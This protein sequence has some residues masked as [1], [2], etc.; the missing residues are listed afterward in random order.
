MSRLGFREAVRRYAILAVLAAQV[1]V[2]SLATPAFLSVQNGVNVLDQVAPVGILAC[3]ATIAIISGVF[4]LSMSSVMAVSGITAVLLSNHLGTPLGWLGGVVVGVVLGAVNGVVCYRGRL[5]SFIATLSTSMIFRG[6]AII[7]TGGVIVRSTAD[8]FG[9]LGRSIGPLTGGA[10]LFLL[11]AAISA[12]VLARTG[13][14]RM[15][16]AVGGNAEAARLAGIQIGVVRV[17]VFMISAGLSAL[18]GLVYASRTQ[19]AAPSMALGIELTAIAAAVLGGTS[20]TGGQGAIWR[21][22]IGALILILIGNGMNLLAVDATFQLAV[23][24]LLILL[25]IS[26]D[27]TLREKED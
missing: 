6:L 22:M 13:Y 19:S 4:D 2:F 12:V 10:W 15:I 8:S 26:M 23:Q 24:G 20:I 3:A 27:Q 5:N 1:V 18:A 17:T 14:G 7:L 11:V 21:G 16:Y 25:A 9:V